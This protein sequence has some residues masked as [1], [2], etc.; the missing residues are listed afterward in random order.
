[1]FNCTKCELQLQPLANECDIAEHLKTSHHSCGRCKKYYTIQRIVEHVNNHHPYECP[2]CRTRFAIEKNLLLH[3]K[4]KHTFKC[5]ICES[6][7]APVF[8]SITDLND[9][10]RRE[11]YGNEGVYCYICHKAFTTETNLRRHTSLKHK[12]IC[13]Y[14]PTE[15]KFASKRQLM[16][17]ITTHHNDFPCY[18]CGRN[19][20]SDRELFL[21]TEQ[22]KPKQNFKCFSCDKSFD[23]LVDCN[24]H[25]TSHVSNIES[26][27]KNNEASN[28]QYNNT[29]NQIRFDYQPWKDDT[30]VI[31]GYGKIQQ[32]INDKYETMKNEVI[33]T[34]ENVSED[35]EKTFK[36]LS[37]KLV[38][39]DYESRLEKVYRENLHNYVNHIKLGDTNSDVARININLLKGEPFDDQVEI[40]LRDIFTTARH[41][42]PY[43]IVLAFGFILYNKSNDDIKQFYVNDHLS[44]DSVERSVIHQLPNIWTIREDKDE[45]KVVDDVVNTDFLAMMTN[46]F[47]EHNYNYVILRATNITGELYSVM[48]SDVYDNLNESLTGRGMIYDSAN[49]N[50]ECDNDTDVDNDNDENEYESSDDYDDDNDDEDDHMD[51]DNND[52]SST[53][54]SSE[55]MVKMIDEYVKAASATKRKVKMLYIGPTDKSFEKLCFFTQLAYWHMKCEK[56]L[57]T[58]KYKQGESCIKVKVKEKARKYFQVF[59]RHYNIEDDDE[60]NGINIKLMAHME[61]LFKTRIN[62][63]TMKDLE[64]DMNNKSNYNHV[65]NKYIPIVQCVHSCRDS[66]SYSNNYKTL[67]LLLHNNHYYT[68]LDR[69]RLFFRKFSCLGCGK[70]F[71]KV[72]LGNL[73]RHM[74]EACN[75]VKTTYARG[76]VKASENM[77]QEAKLLFS[78]PDSLLPKYETNKRLYFTE[79]IVTYDFEALLKKVRAD[80]LK[81]EFSKVDIDIEND[82]EQQENIAEKEEDG[83]CI[84]VN[85][86][87]SY[88]IACNFDSS[89]KGGTNDKTG[90]T[91]YYADNVVPRRLIYTFVKTLLV[92][93]NDRRQIIKERYKDIIEHIEEWFRNRNI[94]CDMTKNCA[95]AFH[96][97]NDKIDRQKKRNKGKKKKTNYTSISEMLIEE[98]EKE[99]SIDRSALLDMYK[100][101]VTVANK[102][103]KILESLP[104]LGFNSAGYDIPLIKKYLFDILIIDFEVAP[105]NIFF[106]KKQS[107]YVNIN[108][109]DIKDGDAGLTFLDIMQYLAPG[110]S[111]DNFVK[112]YG[113]GGDVSM[114]KSYFPYEYMDSYDKLKETQMPPFESF[115]SRLAQE[116]KLESEI[117]DWKRKMNI[118]KTADVSNRLDRPP[119][120]EEKYEILCNEWRERKWKTSRDYLQ[121]YNTQDVVPFLVATLNYARQLQE[122]NVDMFRDGISLPGLAKQI[123]S[124]HIPPNTMYYIDDPTI[125]KSIKDSEVGGQSI[126]FTRS[127]T[128][129]HPYVIG[130]DANSLYLH[131]LGQAHFIKKPIVYDNIVGSIMYRQKAASLYGKPQSKEGELYLDYLEEKLAAKDIVLVREH[132]IHLSDKETNEMKSKFS[133]M[134]ITPTRAQ[135]DIYADGYFV[136]YFSDGRKEER[137]IVEFDGCYWH[138]CNLCRSSKE[139]QSFTRQH[140]NHT[141]VL[142]GEQVRYIDQCKNDVFKNRGMNVIR[143]K[144]C[145]WNKMKKQNENVREYVLKKKLEEKEDPLLKN[146][147]RP[148]MTTQE[149]ITAALCNKQVFGVV[150]CDIHV[151]ED[152]K[153]YFKDFAPI[154]K[155]AN[156]NFD[157]IGDYMQKVATVSDISVK[158]R[159]CVIDSYY[160]EKIGLVDEYFVWLVEKGLVVTKIH[161]FIR[162]DKKNIFK[163]FTNAIT[164]QRIKGDKDKSSEMQA[165]T[166]KLIGNSAFGSCITNK[167]KHRSVELIQVSTNDILGIESNNNILDTTKQHIASINSFVGYEEVTPT[168]LEVSF[169]KLNTQNNQLRFIAL[170]IYCLAKLSVLQFYYDF[171]KEVLEPE[172][173]KLMETDTDSIYIAL[174]NEKFEDN[175]AEDKEDLY[176]KLKKV[177]FIDENSKYGKR[178]PN[179]YKVEFKG[180]R[181]IALCPKSYC[182]YDSKSKNVKFSNKG[183]Q[184]QN[185][186]MSELKENE[187]RG[188]KII[189]MFENALTSSSE[190]SKTGEATNRGLRKKQNEMVM[191]EQ[192]KT[193]FNSFYAKRIVLDDGINTI[194]L[195]I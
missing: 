195:N 176:E 21:H 169:K 88:A 39:E 167:D 86:P 134:S 126:I 35:Q 180:D 68:I 146:I 160:G 164:E 53:K 15:V 92:L 191:D 148:Y 27:S 34:N 31:M 132:R 36:E 44:R 82:S 63:F 47:D 98:Q 25:M 179:R 14:C 194:P 6:D 54:E 23:T 124:K 122:K 168:L 22:H 43:K 30:D 125:F 7:T 185:M 50:E 72:K 58:T 120:G 162:Y 90:Y 190:V 85:I 95:Q 38:K 69:N 130:Y 135:F 161:K 18:Y 114:Q 16:S 56:E 64:K 5:I 143:I 24:R 187:T 75:K 67:D 188:E 183:V 163:Q 99:D 129:K 104:V 136:E 150:I 87:V 11:H 74:Q 28:S 83:E 20:T 70:K 128:E 2:H 77:W 133:S 46:A 139:N 59:M 107:K 89:L 55:E 181:M 166:A 151:P 91:T 110:F 80:K 4:N 19:C 113:V 121:Y 108:V 84:T 1:M 112:S 152:R 147:E 102:L 154:I 12:S 170:V 186:Y 101:E 29:W 79:E 81:E 26:F 49:E 115:Y 111:L 184:K 9:H 96:N 78:I 71:N 177:Y 155:H 33:N 40:A 118:P 3:T 73:K 140:R 97:Y 37:H 178:E 106:I 116:N 174:E 159:R 171:L 61:Y 109:T 165:L 103:K 137:T 62:V 182:V 193:M 158:D 41:M 45:N 192:K 105:K 48:H 13:V 172:S 93:A 144:E 17:H 157:D 142:T 119:T 131:C 189:S 52:N 145:N 51:D 66:Y 156:V 149:C 42:K 123:L 141:V 138:A 65:L 60:F 32:K 153:E 173:F 76:A 57:D 100:K 8:T 10:A 117:N 94:E 175:A 127:T